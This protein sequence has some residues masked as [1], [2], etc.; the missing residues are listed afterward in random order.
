MINKKLGM[1]KKE[2]PAVVENKYGSGMN[3]PARPKGNNNEAPMK[4]VYDSRYDACKYATKKRGPVSHEKTR[5]PAG[6]KPDW[7]Q[8]MV[9][10]AK[11]EDK[12]KA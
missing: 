11:R 8:E 6:L 2:W 12:Y 7:D 1:F 3:P 9:R 10:V 4:S 5:G